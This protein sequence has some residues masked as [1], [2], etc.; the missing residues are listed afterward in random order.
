MSENFRECSTSEIGDYPY[1]EETK[2]TSAIKQQEDTGMKAQKI[3][4]A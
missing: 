1:S 3:Y 4:A 2:A